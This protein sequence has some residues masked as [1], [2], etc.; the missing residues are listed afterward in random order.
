MSTCVQKGEFKQAVS[1][2]KT[3]INKCGII[4]EAG[5][6]CEPTS[7]ILWIHRVENNRG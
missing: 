4:S 5:T 6:V 3:R 7:L 1:V 2:L